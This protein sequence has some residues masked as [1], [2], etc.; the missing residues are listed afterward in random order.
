MNSGSPSERCLSITECQ[1]VTHWDQRS[2]P[3][4]LLLNSRFSWTLS[5]SV[6]SRGVKF[7]L[8]YTSDNNDTVLLWSEG[9]AILLIWLVFANRLPS[10]YFHCSLAYVVVMSPQFVQSYNLLKSKP[11]PWPMTSLVYHG[12]TYSHHAPTSQTRPLIHSVGT[13]VQTCV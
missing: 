9:L 10:W 13:S 1:E 7:G 3:K 6:L 5:L 2:I 4:V 11:K 8:C 12:L